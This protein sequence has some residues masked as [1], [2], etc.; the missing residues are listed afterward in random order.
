MEPDLFMNGISIMR[1]NRKQSNSSLSIYATACQYVR[2]AHFSV[3]LDYDKLYFIQMFLGGT[4]DYT[5][6]SAEPL[7]FLFATWID[8]IFMEQL[9]LFI[10]LTVNN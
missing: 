7:N 6:S 10:S 9:F 2:V 5:I 8:N 4:N 3:Y 1:K